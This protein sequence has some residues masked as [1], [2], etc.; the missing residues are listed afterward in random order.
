MG[1]KGS[2]RD[3]SLVLSVPGGSQC[4]KPGMSPTQT[5]TF[6]VMPAVTLRVTQTVG[7]STLGQDA[8]KETEWINP[9]RCPLCFS[10]GMVWIWCIWVF[11]YFV[12]FYFA[13][14]FLRV[15]PLYKF[16]LALNLLGHT[17]M[18]HQTSL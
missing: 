11:F 3:W 2:S 17:G 14:V 5:Q 10:F 6:S 15:S 8:L 18:Q 4:W 9:M 7:S 12:F 16:W 1:P 13:F